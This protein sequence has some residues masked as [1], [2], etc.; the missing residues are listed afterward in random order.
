MLCYVD[1]PTMRG[2]WHTN[3]RFRQ[4]DVDNL[5]AIAVVCGIEFAFSLERVATT[6]RRTHVTG[7]KLSGVGS[8]SFI[9]FFPHFVC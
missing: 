4:P 5:N 3:F 1:M 2:R 9:T 6:H 8:G 7:C